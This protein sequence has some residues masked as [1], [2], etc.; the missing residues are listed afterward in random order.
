MGNDGP[1]MR[2]KNHM[3]ELFARKAMSNDGPITRTY[4]A[5][6]AEEHTH[7]SFAR[8]VKPL[9]STQRRRK[10]RRNGP[11]PCGSGLKFKNCCLR[12]MKCNTKP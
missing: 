12:R 6:C 4:T 11:C 3:R 10:I 9:G 1:V 7:E 2:T 5:Q 8:M